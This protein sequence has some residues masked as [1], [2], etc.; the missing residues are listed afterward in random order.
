MKKFY[1]LLRPQTLIT[2]PLFLFLFCL[3]LNVKAV[4]LPTTEID[5]V[6][7]SFPPDGDNTVEKSFDGDLSTRWSGDGDG[8][9]ITYKL[10]DEHDFDSLYI[11]FKSNHERNSY[12][13]IKYAGEDTTTWVA[14]TTDL[15]GSTIN[16]SDDD[17]EGFDCG[18]KAMYIRIE[19]YGNTQNGWLS[20]E[21]I[22]FWVDNTTAVH[23]VNANTMKIYPNPASNYINVGLEEIKNVSI[24]DI[25]GRT[26]ATYGDLSARPVI[27]FDLTPGGYFIKAEALDN[28]TYVQKLMVK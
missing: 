24:I 23:E 4:K 7:S 19:G 17:F 25:T 10:K 20:I 12:F 22:E 18:F 26:I 2:I 9:Q 3:T 27:Y 1:F 5:T 28:K 21:E 13:F 14:T 6:W 8:V 15:I 16:A 11:N